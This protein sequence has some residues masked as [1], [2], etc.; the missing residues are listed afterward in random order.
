MTPNTWSAE[1]GE[2]LKALRTAAQIDI[3][4]L[5]RHH[6]LSLSQIRQLEEGG[7][8]AFYSQD[9]KINAGRKLLQAL[10]FDMPA[11]TQAA[12]DLDDVSNKTMELNPLKCVSRISMGRIKNDARLMAL[13]YSLALGALLSV[14]WMAGDFFRHALQIPRIEVL[15]DI[16][17]LQTPAP[18]IVNTKLEVMPSEALRSEKLLDSSTSSSVE[19]IT[20]NQGN[21]EWRFPEKI[22]SSPQP[23]K[24]G[25]YVHV[26]ALSE[27]QVCIRD[28]RMEETLLS[29]KP[30]QAKSVY[31]LSPFKVY[32][33]SYKN[34]RLFYQGHQVRMPEFDA[35]HLSLNEQKWTLP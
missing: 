2:R 5:A 29:L 1:D 21:C 34:V 17:P 19:K 26:V 15:T 23:V 27:I 11:A 32:S 8:S 6:T 3:T 28:A 7:N 24:P 13:I 12:P 35:V 31:G 33:S 9:I 4:T 25:N 18:L 22:L 30:G 16:S 10:G 14:A 20:N